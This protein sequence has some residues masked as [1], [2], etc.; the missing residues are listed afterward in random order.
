[1]RSPPARAHNGRTSSAFTAGVYDR[2]PCRTAR[3]HQAEPGPAGDRLWVYSRSPQGGAAVG[4]PVGP[5][6]A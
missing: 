1:M 4:L 6:A 2:A 3:I 5:R